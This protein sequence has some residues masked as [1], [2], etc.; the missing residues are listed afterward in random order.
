MV[1][2]DYLCPFSPH[3]LTQQWA[4]TTAG[5]LPLVVDRQRS[6]SKSTPRALHARSHSTGHRAAMRTLS[7]SQP[8]SLTRR[9]WLRFT[10]AMEKMIPNGAPSLVGTDA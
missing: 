10:D 7:L 2:V 4:A 5:R 6:V 3:S 9:A 1:T 8:S